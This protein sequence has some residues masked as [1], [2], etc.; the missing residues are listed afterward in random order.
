MAIKV[1]LHLLRTSHAQGLLFFRYRRHLM[2]KAAVTLAW[3]DSMNFFGEILRTQTPRSILFFYSLDLLR[4]YHMVGKDMK[5]Q[6]MTYFFND[7]KRNS[8]VV[9]WN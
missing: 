2:N 8:Q 3:L 5:K 4:F 1:T 6:K 7:R 9:F